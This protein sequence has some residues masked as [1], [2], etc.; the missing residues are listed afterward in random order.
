MFGE[1]LA[2]ISDSII[3]MLLAIVLATIIVRKHVAFFAMIFLGIILGFSMI[4]YEIDKS[5]LIEKHNGEKVYASGVV[6]KIV[7]TKYF[8]SL[9]LTNVKLSK[10]NSSELFVETNQIIAYVK[11][12]KDISVGNKVYLSGD[13]GLFDTAKNPGNFSPRQYYKS[14][15]IYGA[16]ENCEIEKTEASKDTIR[17]NL[18]EFKETISNQLDKITDC[19]A[20]YKSILLGN[21]NEIDVYSNAGIA[22]I[23]AISGL[24]VSIIGLALFKLLRRKF[25]YGISTSISMTTIVLFGVMTG[26]GISTSRAIIMFL[27]KMLAE[28][29]GKKYD[30]VTSISMAFVTIC[31]WNP[32]AIL[33]SGFQ[34]SFA[35]I[36][37]VYIIYP[38]IE[39][40]LGQ[41]RSKL[42]KALWFSAT[43]NMVMA[44]IV[45][46]NYYQISTYST[47]L[48]M[49]VVPL[50]SIVLISGIFGVTFSFINITLGKIFIFPGSIV[51]KFCQWLSGVSLKV[52]GA[53]IVVGRPGLLQIAVYY[54]LLVI[55]LVV[56][57]KARKKRNKNEAGRKI[58]SN[59]GEAIEPEY[60]KKKGQKKYNYKITAFLTIGILLTMAIIYLKAIINLVLPP[61]E[62]QITMMDVG[63]GEG[64]LISNSGTNILID[65]GS[66]SVDKVGKYRI[67]PFLKYS[68]VNQIDYAIV[69]HGDADHISGVEEIIENSD[70]DGLKVKN[71][72][73]SN[74][75]SVDSGVQKLVKLAEKHSINILCISKGDEINFGKAKLKCLHPSSNASGYDVNDHSIV[76]TLMYNDFS[77]L[78][79][80]DISSEI[81]SEL[82]REQMINKNIDVLKVPHH[83]SKYSSSKE[84]VNRTNPSIALISAGQGNMYGHP[85]KE[86]LDILKDIGSSIY[87]TD[88]KG[89]IVLKIPD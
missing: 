67:I 5:Q 10:A 39:Y 35:A 82:I 49:I 72:V 27:L 22:H 41:G 36:A 34:M 45:A 79:T 70:T 31:I 19:T 87:R 89:A 11:P 14:L 2:V 51:L 61:K 37:A 13:L 4:K 23:F 43:I 65:G 85:H 8:L 42:L 26:M 58:T 68:C 80:G 50:M 66:I 28:V 64:I 52:P 69:T 9:N 73:I 18:F 32:F 55:L 57:Y 83:G 29:T 6:S 60:R 71:L 81:E 15:G 21:K 20:E 17:D 78:F 63:Q 1:A 59:R 75:I 25:G 53:N 48:N 44:P 62:L 16:L 77:M 76:M 46:Y 33:N 56:F 24:H 30:G 40:I 74:A 47:L 7:E 12:V 86:T 84:F 54:F 38:V 88:E 3:I